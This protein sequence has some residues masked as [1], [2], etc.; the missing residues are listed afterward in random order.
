MARVLEVR[1]KQ[2]LY[3]SLNTPYPPLV[4]LSAKVKQR[5]TLCATG[6]ML[7]CGKYAPVSSACQGPGKKRARERPCCMLCET[8]LDVPTPHSNLNADSLCRTLAAPVGHRVSP[9]YML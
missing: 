4:R 2:V 3:L 9:S 7:A 6:T 8:T 5:R 1:T